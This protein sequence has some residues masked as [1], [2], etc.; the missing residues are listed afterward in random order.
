[1]RLQA[2]IKPFLEKVDWEKMVKMWFPKGKKEARENILSNIKNSLVKIEKSWNENPDW[3]I[4]QVLVNNGIM[5]NI[6]GMWYYMEED[7]ILIDLGHEARE[8]IF[9]GVNFTKEMERLPETKWT[10]IKDLE[11]DHI[12][13]IL[14]GGYTKNPLYLETFEAELKRRE[15]NGE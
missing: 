5:P 11:S 7:D 4:S 1:M 14:D 10:L 9:W 15:K 2:R 13:A 12:Q 6:L 8:V 3:R